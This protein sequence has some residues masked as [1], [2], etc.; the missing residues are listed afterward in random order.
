MKASLL[1]TLQIII[2]MPSI[3][4]TF[5]LPTSLGLIFTKIFPWIY[6][7]CLNLLW[8]LENALL[9]KVDKLYFRKIYSVRACMW[10]KFV[11]LFVSYLLTSASGLV[12]FQNHPTKGQVID[13]GTVPHYCAIQY[14]PNHVHISTR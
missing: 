1:H 10:R 6:S 5:S 4:L 3:Q 2:L 11:L 12:C 7:K 13:L 8:K 14:S 9:Y